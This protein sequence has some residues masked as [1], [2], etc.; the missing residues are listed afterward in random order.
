[1]TILKKYMIQ[2]LLLHMESDDC[3]ILILMLKEFQL[4]KL[5]N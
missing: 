5:P 1:M 4:R 2:Q 3:N